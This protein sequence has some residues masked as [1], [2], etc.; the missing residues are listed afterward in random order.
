LHNVKQHA[1]HPSGLLEMIGGVSKTTSEAPRSSVL[2]FGGR[3]GAHCAFDSEDDDV[4][5]DW[6]GTD[7]E[8]GDKEEIEGVV[9]WE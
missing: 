8:D 1:F 6:G 2:H 4:D 7:R 9:A 3:F 5:E